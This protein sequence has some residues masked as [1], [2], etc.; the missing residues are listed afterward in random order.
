MEDNAPPSLIEWL[1]ELGSIPASAFVFALACTAWLV[2]GR[3]RGCFRFREPAPVRD[4]ALLLSGPVCTILISIIKLAAG[5]RAYLRGGLDT[6]LG[7]IASLSDVIDL[8][9]AGIV[10]FAV[11]LV[12]LLLPARSR[13]KDSLN[14]TRAWPGTGARE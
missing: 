2:G 9:V 11:G 3:I 4:I 13:A 14:E 1:H 12:S 5:G 8:C 10:L 7:F 6:D